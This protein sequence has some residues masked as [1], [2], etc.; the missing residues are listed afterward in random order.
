MEM[1]RSLRGDKNRCER[2]YFGVR[3]VVTVMRESLMEKT[4]AS[5]YYYEKDCNLSADV[6]PFSHS[7]WNTCF[8]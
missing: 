5:Y 4:S 6:T 1:L 8:E 7:K 2:Q 3:N